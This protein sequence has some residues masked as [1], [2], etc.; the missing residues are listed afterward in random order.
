MDLESLR[1]ELIKQ[2]IYPQVLATADGWECTLWCGIGW[3]G[4]I[5]KGFGATAVAA[6]QAAMVDRNS[7][8]D[9]RKRAG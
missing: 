2:G 1:L 3:K 8:L 9:S 7:I 4:T 5:P 6:V